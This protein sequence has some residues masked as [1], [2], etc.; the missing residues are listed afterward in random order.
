MINSPYVLIV[1]NEPEFLHTLG[2]RLSLRNFLPLLASSA[3]EAIEIAKH[4]PL[5]LAIVNHSLTDL[6][7]DKL[8]V[9]LKKLKPNLH[10]ILVT[11]YSKKTYQ[12]EKNLPIIDKKNLEELWN[13]IGHFTPENKIFPKSN[14]TAYRIPWIIGETQ[15]IQKLKK[16]LN[17]IAIL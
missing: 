3:T 5:N 6:N 15:K 2:K 10:I 4:H 12:K 7:G 14:L 16:N 17:K 8:A 13:I 9:K 11:E 1:D